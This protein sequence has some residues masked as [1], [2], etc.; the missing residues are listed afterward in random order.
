MK[1]R[2]YH[3]GPGA[4][5]LLLII[6]VVS[7]SVLGLLSL[8]SARGEYRLTE[9]SVLFARYGHEASVQAEYKLAQLDAVLAEGERNSADDESYLAAVEANLPEGM[10][11]DG[12]TVSWVEE[13]ENGRTLLCA[14]EVLPYGSEERGRWKE[15]SFLPIETDGYGSMNFDIW[16]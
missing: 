12:R 9:R 11:M 15:H 8:I 4:V 13:A 5:S 2:E 7:M 14:V 1:N 10:E 3:V 6:V 16:E